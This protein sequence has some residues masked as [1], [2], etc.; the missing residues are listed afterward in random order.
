MCPVLIKFPTRSGSGMDVRTAKNLTQ[1][2]TDFASSPVE[3]AV[4]TL[5]RSANIVPFV[6]DLSRWK[7]S[8]NGLGDANPKHIKS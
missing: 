6:G 5:T 4:N 2:T 7:T 3:S 8:R 1:I